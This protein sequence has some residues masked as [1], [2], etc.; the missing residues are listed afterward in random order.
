MNSRQRIL[1]ALDHKE[2]DRVPF[3]LGSCQVS[4][5]HVVAYKNLRKALASQFG[6]SSN[7]VPKTYGD[8]LMMLKQRGVEFYINT[9]FLI[10]SKIGTSDDLLEKVSVK[11]FKLITLKGM[12]RLR[13]EAKYY[14]AY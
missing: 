9:G 8:F 3:D 4:G 10:V 2:P 11:F 13:T 12:V 5:I 7:S 1:T 6:V 14:M